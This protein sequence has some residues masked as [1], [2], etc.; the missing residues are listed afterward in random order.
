MSTPI[1]F[2]PEY[3]EKKSPVNEQLF[4]RFL[5]SGE[6]YKSLYKN[7][8]HQSAKHGYV[9]NPKTVGE[10]YPTL[11]IYNTFSSEDALVL[12]KSGHLFK[13]NK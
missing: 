4:T 2:T 13:L 7:N 1:E 10:Q 6:P 12:K 11:G 3:I 5:K 9:A 8:F